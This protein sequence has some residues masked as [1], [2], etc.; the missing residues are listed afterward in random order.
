M[1]V[2]VCVRFICRLGIWHTLNSWVGCWYLRAACSVLMTAII[3]IVSQC[4]CAL[5]AVQRRNLPQNYSVHCGTLSMATSAFV[6]MMEQVWYL[7][8][9]Y[10]CSKMYICRLL[11]MALNEALQPGIILPAAAE[12][13]ARRHA[14]YFDYQGSDAQGS[15]AL[16]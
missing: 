4:I 8:G 3:W 12:C 10:S 13:L 15:D 5:A 2:C 11:N 16:A 14:C 6:R 7:E 9:D 1:S